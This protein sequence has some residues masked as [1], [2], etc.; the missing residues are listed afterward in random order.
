M[1]YNLEKVHPNNKD[2]DKARGGKPAGAPR[3]LIVTTLSLSR[4][5]EPLPPLCLLSSRART[6]LTDCRPHPLGEPWST[7]SR[8]CTLRTRL[9]AKACRRAPRLLSH[10]S[11]SLSLALP[12][13]LLGTS[14]NPKAAA[15]PKLRAVSKKSNELIKRHHAVRAAYEVA[16]HRHQL[17]QLTC[18]AGPRCPLAHR[19][20]AKHL[21]SHPLPHTRCQ[22]R[23]DSHHPSLRARQ[24]QRIAT[25]S[26]TRSSPHRYI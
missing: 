14:C 19:A 5:R 1:E 2:K 7:T 23:R 11:L 26:T 6:T 17:V 24:K 4:E 22:A 10:N 13:E 12:C 20:R 8:R 21:Y 9:V 3:L 16:N 15:Q 18:P 25:T